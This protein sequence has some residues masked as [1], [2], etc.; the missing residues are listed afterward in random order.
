MEERCCT[1]CGEEAPEFDGVYYEVEGVSYPKFQN[2]VKGYNGNFNTHD[3]EEVH[4]CCG[5]EF[6]IFDGI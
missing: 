4:N 2:E 1:T 3:W 5:K 6:V